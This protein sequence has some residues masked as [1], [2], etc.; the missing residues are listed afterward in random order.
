MSISASQINVAVD[1]LRRWGIEKLDGIRGPQHRSAQVGERVHTINEHWLTSGMPPN[2]EE[3]LVIDGSEYRPGLT[4]MNGLH[5]LPPPGPHIVVESS[6]HFGIWTGRIDFA[7]VSING[8]YVPREQWLAMKDS[9]DVIPGCGDHKTSGSPK[10]QY[11]LDEETL[12]TDVQATVYG[13]ALHEEFP[14]S[15]EADRLWNYLGT[16]KPFLSKK[17]HLRVHKDETLYR[18]E[19]MNRLAEELL[20]LRSSGLKGNDLPPNTASCNKYGGCPHRGGHCHLS[21]AEQ[22]RSHMQNGQQTMSLDEQ[23]QMA[24]QQASAANGMMVPVPAQSEWVEHPENSAYEYHSVTKE[25]RQKQTA[26]V[27]QIPALPPSPFGAPSAPIVTLSA[28][29]IPIVHAAPTVV[30]TL[31]PIVAVIPPTPI[32]PAPVVT[33]GATGTPIGPDGLPFGSINAPEGVGIPPRTQPVVAA[34]AVVDDLDGMDKKQL[35]E[36]AGRMG[37]DVKRLQEKG[38]RDRLRAARAQGVQAGAAPA[39]ATLSTGFVQ[40]APPPVV[41]TMPSGTPVTSIPAEEIFATSTK[42]RVYGIVMALVEHSGAGWDVK[43]GVAWA[44][45]LVAEIES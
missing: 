20:R 2:T 36:L 7:W 1:C 44:R 38:I 25:L 12:R 19:P 23:I 5:N 27:L 10:F 41:G 15:R 16:K 18:L 4:A 32:A 45:A 8:I 28:P 39:V 42:D 3:R 6:F 26:P 35:V 33:I 30:Q 29:A 24:T 34:P 17:V 9:T 13:A 43:Q 37:V 14:Q 40:V 11:A 31:P 22:M 21:H